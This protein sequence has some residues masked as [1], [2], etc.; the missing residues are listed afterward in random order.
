MNLILYLYRQFLETVHQHLIRL[1][2][3]RKM[4]QWLDSLYKAVGIQVI[5]KYLATIKILPILLM[6]CILIMHLQAG[7]MNG[8]NLY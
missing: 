6:G 1:Y 4:I 8:N 3:G 2:L 5:L 7:D